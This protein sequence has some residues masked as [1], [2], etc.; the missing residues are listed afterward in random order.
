MREEESKKVKALRD[1][2]E[3]KVCLSQFIE[4]R[5]SFFL[6]SFFYNFFL[7]ETL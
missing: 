3:R 5:V 1:Q 7:K 6:F 2:E 4:A